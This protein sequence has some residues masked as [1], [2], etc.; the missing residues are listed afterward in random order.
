MIL[1]AGGGIGGLAAALALHQAGIPCAVY[2]QAATVRELGV[3]INTLPHA[4]RALANLGLLPALD[5]VGIRTRELI[6]ANRFGQPVWTE[7]RG[8]HAGHDAPQFSI[9]RGKLLTVLHEAA[10]ARGIQIHPGHR[11]Q[12]FEQDANTVT[13]RFENGATARGTALIGA[14]GI[15]SA[16]RAAF[17]NEGPPR[18]TGIMLWRGALEWPVFADGQTMLIAGGMRAKFVLYPIHANPA[19][20]GAR[21][22]N[23]VV[24]ARIA[25]GNTPP[26]NREDWSRPGRLQDLLPFVQD[27]F[28]LDRLGLIDP[29]SLIEASEAFY[30]YPMV[31]RDPLPQWTHGRVT[32]LGDAAHPMYPVGSNGASQAILDGVALA[33]CLKAGIPKGLAAYEAERRPATTEIVLLNRAGGPERV[34][35]VIE[36]RAPHGFN[37]IESIAPHA[38][39]KAIVQNYAQTAGFAANQIK[40]P[41]KQ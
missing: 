32:L 31:D 20:P 26:P 16:I 18:W 25:D 27:N 11:L 5:A 33:R 30:E 19:Q 38:E 1:L 29:L 17:I 4:I 36:E 13:A 40:T 9:H 10:I 21:L 35:D 39:R 2:E 6:L 14:D 23:W 37:N 7:L 34:I 8:T 3:G 28:Q 41:N 15:H 22:T 24:Q 12:T